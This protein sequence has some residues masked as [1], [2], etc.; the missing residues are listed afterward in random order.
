VKFAAN[1]ASVFRSWP[2]GPLGGRTTVDLSPYLDATTSSDWLGVPDSLAGPNAVAWADTVDDNVPNPADPDEIVRR[3]ASFV[4]PFDDFTPAENPDGHCDATHQCTWDLD[5]PFSWQANRESDITNG[6]WLVNRFHDHLEDDP[7]IAFGPSSGNFEGDD[8][9]VVNGL[10]GAAGPNGTEGL[11]DPLHLSNANMLTPPDGSSPLM[12]MYLAGDQ[13]GYSQRD[14]SFD[15]DPATVWHEYTH[16][17]STRLVA[18]GGVNSPQ[19]GAMG[20]G[21]SDWYA[22]DWMDELGMITGTS[23]GAVDLGLYPDPV[24]N[25]TR[26]QPLDCPVGTGDPDCPG[27]PPRTP[28]GGYTYASFGQI[29]SC[30]PEVHADSEIWSETLWDLRE[31]IGQDDAQ[32]LITDGMRMSVTEPSFLDMRNAI[33]A[34]DEADFGGS[35]ADTIWTVFAHRGMGFFAGAVDGGDVHPVADDSM[36][37]AD[38]APTGTVTGRVLDQDTG[39]P[40]E[41][42]VVGFGGHGPP[43]YQDT[44]D[45]SGRFSLTPVEGTYPSFFINGPGYDQPAG[46]PATVDVDGG[47]TTDLG[48]RVLRRNYASRSGGAAIAATSDTNSG[49]CGPGDAIDGSQTTGWSTPNPNGSQAPDPPAPTPPGMPLGTPYMTVTLPEAVDIATFAIDPSETCGDDETAAVGRLVVETS[50]DGTT[51]TTALDK[52]FGP[53]DI[54][55]LNQIAPM[56]GGTGVTTI[57]ISLRSPQDDSPGSSGQDWIDLTELKIYGSPAAPPPFIP[58]SGGGG[59][60][61]GTPTTPTTPAPPPTPTTP[62]PPPSS[63][64]LPSTNPVPR[65]PIGTV[66]VRRRGRLLA[67]IHCDRACSARGRLLAGRKLRKLLHRKPSTLDKHTIRLKRAGAATLT[68]QLSRKVRH[69]LHRRHLERVTVTLK[70]R[71]RESDGRIST[72]SRRVRIRV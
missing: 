50:T 2:G 30:G 42:A 63:P 35:H 16:G 24:K 71:V 58:P 6:F 26:T 66:S 23:P 21:W 57:R 14:V 47:A 68:L 25:E 32:K 19:A 59:G 40:V 46:L 56:A 39:A 53:T 20:E 67:R 7:Q 55:K 72:T 22:L 3:G 60:G 11:P 52:T 36:P 45:S 9:V 49:G 10:D 51:F 13:P 33:L 28:A 27:R 17:L 1:D 4:F 43:A 44:T 48:D 61:G 65:S 18:N 41:G 29:C 31:T 69:R 37:P 34:A 8:P 38:G 62:V 5:V 64:T 54:H 15:Y 12:Q 70:I